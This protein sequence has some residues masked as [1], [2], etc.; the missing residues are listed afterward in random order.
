[1]CA[2][3]SCASAQHTDVRRADPAH[4]RHRGVEHRRT[5][6]ELRAGQRP[7]SA[8]LGD[9][10][11]LAALHGAALLEHRPPPRLERRPQPVGARAHEQPNRRRV[12]PPKQWTA[13]EAEEDD[14]E[15]GED[16]SPIA[17][18][19]RLPASSAGVPSLAR[20]RYARGPSLLSP[21]AR[22]GA[23]AGNRTIWSMACRSCGTAQ[24]ANTVFPEPLGPSRARARRSA[25]HPR[26]N[27]AL[28][29]RFRPSLA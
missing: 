7:V 19:G 9:K 27:P 21:P 17:S 28:R 20:S 6:C 2:S 14:E 24:H 26:S 12:S 22:P 23:D 29:R 18:P 15:E 25:L 16:S 10:A 4:G 5:S 3:C 13:A 11:P 8:L 1:M